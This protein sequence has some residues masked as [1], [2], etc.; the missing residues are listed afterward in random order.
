MGC[1]FDKVPLI[2]SP[3]RSDVALATAGRPPSN[4]AATAVVPV[5]ENTNVM[6]MANAVSE[7]RRSVDAFMT[8]PGFED[9]SA[10]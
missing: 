9:E 4:P 8:D 2:A 5:V 7:E 10:P 3:G 6:A 1:V